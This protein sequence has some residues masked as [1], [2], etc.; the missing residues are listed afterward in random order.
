MAM[1]IPEVF[2]RFRIDL[3]IPSCAQSGS[4][5]PTLSEMLFRNSYRALW[6]I[7]LALPGVALALAGRRR[8]AWVP[9]VVPVL[10]T[11]PWSGSTPGQ[12]GI[13]NYLGVAYP[14]DVIEFLSARYHPTGLIGAMPWTVHPMLALVISSV[15][16]LLPA[17]FF[18]REVQVDRRGVGLSATGVVSLAICWSTIPAITWLASTYQGGLDWV[19]DWFDPWF[20][21]AFVVFLFA[22]LVRRQRPLW[23]WVHLG[24][25]VLFA[26]QVVPWAMTGGDPPMTILWWTIRDGGRATVVLL[27]V[28]FAGAQWDRVS[29]WMVARRIGANHVLAI[30]LGSYSA[31]LGA[32]VFLGGG[33]SMPWET[34][35]PA[36]FLASLFWTAGFP[37]VLGLG[38]AHL[39]GKRETGERRWP[40][41]VAG[42]LSELGVALGIVWF[43]AGVI[44]LFT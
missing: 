28:A 17:W 43:A 2:N 19:L 44:S 36:E 4:T 41:R 40:G 23:P 10:V 5:C 21:W 18:G 31:Y 22:A 14:S 26:M 16:V 20:F 24:I 34:N 15:L 8:M 37:I 42:A 7:A 3:V 12:F 39:A 25:P 11:W 9:F 1:W 27:V 32:R 35:G 30:A 38:A 6:Y 33:A 13:E 29:D